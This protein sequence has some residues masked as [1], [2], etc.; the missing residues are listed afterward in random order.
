MSDE[1]RNIGIAGVIAGLVIGIVA[2]HLWLGR[3]QKPLASLPETAKKLAEPEFGKGLFGD[4]VPL[5]DGGAY[6]VD[7]TQDAV[8]DMRESKAI[9]VQASKSPLPGHSVTTKE[10]PI[11]QLMTPQ[12]AWVLL[13]HAKRME[14]R[15]QEEVD[16]LRDQIPDD[17]G[18]ADDEIFGE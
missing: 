6:Y 18:F 16:G 4:V 2:T 1:S 11:S 14:R 10:S 9:R 15:A 8:W 7:S 5:A 17:A 12:G 3:T 13:Q